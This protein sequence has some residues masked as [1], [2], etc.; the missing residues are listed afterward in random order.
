MMYTFS[1]WQMALSDSW[2]Q[3]WGAFLGILPRILGAV[4][5]FAIG[6][7]L[8]YWVKRIIVEVLNFVKFEK[9]SQVSGI[10]KYLK[11]A[12]IQLSL[13]DLIGTVFEWLIILI[14]FLAFVDILGLT[15]VSQ[16]LFGVLGY[17]PNIIAAIFI[18]AAGYI[19]AG[20]VEG[21]VRGALASVDHAVAKPLGKFARWLILIIALFA[22]IEQ[23]QIAKGLVSVFYQGLTYTVVLAVGLS[24]GLGAKDVIAKI[25]EDWYEKVK[26]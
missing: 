18:F 7:I 12:D 2:I 11:K 22:S 25:L 5:I 24:I 6:M 16:V 10:G 14:F 19:V 20:I 15:A 23:L 21:L 9:L 4:I 1:S 3:V 13:S 26:R 17:I 8:A